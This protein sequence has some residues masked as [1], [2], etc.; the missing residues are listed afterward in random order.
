M[1]KLVIITALSILAVLGAATK[2]LAP[3]PT[4]TRQTLTISV[5]ELHRQVDASS[6]PVLQVREPF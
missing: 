2:P 5:D 6:V 3:V 4:A 1:A